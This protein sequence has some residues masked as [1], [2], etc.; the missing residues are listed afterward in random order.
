MHSIQFLRGSAS[1]GGGGEEHPIV[2]LTEE[3]LRVVIGGTDA[4]LASSTMTGSYNQ[5]TGTFCCD[6]TKVCCCGDNG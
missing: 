3:E 1:A 2:Q 6:G 4:A 5:P